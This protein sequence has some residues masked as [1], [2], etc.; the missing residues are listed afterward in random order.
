MKIAL[1]LSALLAMPCANLMATPPYQLRLDITPQPQNQLQVIGYVVAAQ[2]ETLDYR[3]AMN[4]TGATGVSRI[5]Q[6]GR[7]RLQ[8]GKET[9]T[10]RFSFNLQPGD[11]YSLS[12]QLM[13]NGMLLAQETISQ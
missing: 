2:E 12:M 7:L 6:G 8:P 4:K 13:K 9:A 3:L 1:F 10:S 11:G 5:N